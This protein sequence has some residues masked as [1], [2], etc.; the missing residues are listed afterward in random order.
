M[1]TINIG[2]TV[3]DF[4]NTAESADWSQPVISFAEAAADAINASVGAADVLPNTFNIDA[5]NGASLTNIPGFTF[6]TTI[7]RSTEISYSIIRERDSTTLV[8]SGI[9]HAVYNPN[10]NSTE[11]F[12]VTRDYTGDAQSE[13]DITDEG[14]VQISTTAISGVG[15]HTGVISFSAKSLLA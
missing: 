3:I 8:E 6:D 11:K 9:I 15:S 7:I 2:S 4:P 1:P 5:L 12:V 13:L 10:G 14:Q